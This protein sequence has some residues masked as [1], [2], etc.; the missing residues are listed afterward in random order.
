MEYNGWTNWE[1]WNFKLWLDNDEGLYNLINKTAT[2]LVHHKKTFAKALKMVADEVVG[3]ELCLDL[4]KENIPDIN[5]NE[6]SDY[7]LEAFEAE[8]EAAEEGE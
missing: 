1:T 2:V 6:I 7:I 3:T 5:F 4:K 8:K